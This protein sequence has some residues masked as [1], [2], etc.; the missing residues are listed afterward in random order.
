[1]IAKLSDPGSGNCHVTLMVTNAGNYGSPY[2]NI[3]F[4]EIS[5]RGLPSLLGA[6]GTP[7]IIHSRRI[8]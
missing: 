8:C 5:A 7:G 2:G 6:D 4:I 1:K 3:D